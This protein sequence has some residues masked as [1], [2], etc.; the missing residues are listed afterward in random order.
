MTPE[1]HRLLTAEC[2]D[3]APGQ[4]NFGADN[5]GTTVSARRFGPSELHIE[6]RGS[7]EVVDWIVLDNWYADLKRYC[8]ILGQAPSHAEIE[9]QE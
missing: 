4:G 2:W 9:R 6:P 1:A 7:L 8:E 3:R 5:L